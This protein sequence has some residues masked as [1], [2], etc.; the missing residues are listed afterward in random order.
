MQEE[1]EVNVFVN[2]FLAAKS[3]KSDILGINSKEE[4]EMFEEAYRQIFPEAE[5]HSE[6]EWTP[7]LADKEEED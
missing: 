6:A 1:D 4:A 3:G 7:W 5:I 2:G